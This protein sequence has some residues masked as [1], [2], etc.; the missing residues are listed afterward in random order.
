MTTLTNEPEHIV[1]LRDML[2]NF[3]EKEMPRDT[4]ARWDRDDELPAA[5]LENLAALGVMGVTFPEQYGGIGRDIYAAMVVIEELS[6]RSIAVAAP[7]I[8]S[9]C[10]AGMN[11]L[12]SGSEEQKRSMLPLVAQGKLRFA[13]GLTEPDVGA[14]LA[15]VKT[16]AQVDGNELVVSGAKRF[17]TGAQH[18]DYIYTL[19]KSDSTAP[20]YQ[21]LTIVLIP[22]AAQGL[23]I[24]PI[25]AIGQRGPGTTDV[26]LDEVRVSVEMIL[27]GASQLNKGWNALA[28]ST[29]SVERLEVA[30]MALGIGEAAL[31]DAWIYSQ[32]RHQFGK[33]ICAHQAVRHHLAK[34][35]TQLMAC[36]LMLYN[37]A[38]MANA[39]LPCDAESSMAKLFVCQEV[40]EVVLSCQRVMGAYGCVSGSDMER[41]VREALVFPIAGGS[42]EI[43]LK[44]IANRF[45]LPRK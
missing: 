3:V 11:L 39:D 4:V 42:T 14:D 25:D 19:A 41:Y 30:A 24:E 1:A 20:R 10:Y 9:T 33:P 18:A 15:A 16:K 44:N 2:Q 23:S 27:G 6:K 8:M 21:N 13:Y 43:Q 26:F 34:A 36:R 32:D 37:V 40:Q 35:K 38:S 22:V 28:G 7:Y 17:C 29:L 31:A 45:G 5:V 12:E